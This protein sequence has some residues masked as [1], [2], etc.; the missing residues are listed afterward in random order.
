MP[1]ADVAVARAPNRVIAE[2]WAELLGT[3][4]IVC[5]IVPVHPGGSIYVPN[6][7]ALELR[8][9]AIDAARAID[10][11]PA[12]P[13]HILR[14]PTEDEEEPPV[15]PVESRLRWAFFAAVGVL[16]VAIIALAVRCSAAAGYL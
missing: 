8:V 4:G 1:E 16:L 12:E 9:P 13:Q 3:H 5:R 11:L 2:M 10:L 15:D 7:E 14:V 6:E